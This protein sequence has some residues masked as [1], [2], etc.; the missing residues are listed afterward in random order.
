MRRGDFRTF[1]EAPSA[2][3][4][5]MAAQTT[6]GSQAKAAPPWLSN[7]FVMS[8]ATGIADSGMTQARIP[9]IGFPT[10]GAFGG[11]TTGTGGSPDAP[12]DAG[13][14]TVT[15][16]CWMASVRRARLRLRQAMPAQTAKRSMPPSPAIA[17][18][19]PP[20]ARLQRPARTELR[21]PA[22]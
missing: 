14:T 6:G 5:G 9:Q 16:G 1:G 12:V 4:K 15:V 3:S 17:R 7:S 8:N 11:A 13:A 21:I 22:P 2:T 10:R 18:G 20:R 19:K